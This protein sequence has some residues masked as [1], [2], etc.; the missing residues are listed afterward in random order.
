ME[1][2][3]R[4][5]LGQQRTFRKHDGLEVSGTRPPPRRENGVGGVVSWMKRMLACND[6]KRKQRSTS[7]SFVLLW[8]V[9]RPISVD[10]D[11]GFRLRTRGWMPGRWLGDLRD[12]VGSVARAQWDVRTKKMEAEGTVFEDAKSVVNVY[13][14]V[15][16]PEGG[17]EKAK[18]LEAVMGRW[19]GERGVSR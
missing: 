7:S 18:V 13:V 6:G 19:T 8:S 14:W 1:A 4:D 3:V 10:N 9:R 15:L 11:E 17:D 16:V 2:K 5:G 12:G